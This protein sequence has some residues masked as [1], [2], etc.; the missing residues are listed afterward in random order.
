[1]VFSQLLDGFGV[2]PIKETLISGGKDET[3]YNRSGS[4]RF[5]TEPR[6]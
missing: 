3:L 6:S 2:N 4:N 5:K 1:M